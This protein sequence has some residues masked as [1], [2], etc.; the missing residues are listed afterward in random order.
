MRT[1]RSDVLKATG[2]RQLCAGHDGGSEIAYHAM[3]SIFQDDSTEGVLIVDASNAFN[4][5]NRQV[6]LLNIHDVCPAIATVL[7]NCYRSES[8]LFVQGEML[9][10]REGTTQGDPLAMAMFALASVPLIQKVETMGAK[11]AWFAD[12]AASGG[13]LVRL[14]VWWDRLNTHGPVYGYFPNCS[15]T[16]L[17]VKAQYVEKARSVFQGTKININTEG[18]RYLGGTIGTSEF[19]KTY[20]ESKV[21]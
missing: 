9:L 17:V 2:I 6:A 10:S 3:Q 20:L 15:K 13:R 14:R 11:Q 21:A 7:T 8:P 18:K 4:N 16:N 19:T 5:L 12:D 1:V